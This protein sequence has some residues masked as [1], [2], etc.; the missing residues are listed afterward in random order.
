M[1]GPSAV[2]DASISYQLSA[3]ELLTSVDGLVSSYLKM[4]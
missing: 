2:S 4:C 3:D 1:V